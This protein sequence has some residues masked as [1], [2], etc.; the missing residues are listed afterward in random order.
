MHLRLLFRRRQLGHERL[1]LRGG[2]PPHGRR[3][4]EQG[5]EA[6]DRLSLVEDQG[7]AI[8]Q[9]VNVDPARGIGAAVGAWLDGK[10]LAAEGEG[11]VI[12]HE[13]LMFE[14]Q[15]VLRRQSGGPGPIRQ[16]LFS[17]RHGKAGVE[18]QQRL[19]D[20]LEVGRSGLPQGLDQAVLEG[21]EKALDA[22]FGLG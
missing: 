16:R 22:A 11:V 8:E 4:G 17:R 21:P 18:A 10:P 20:L 1:D 2:E 14:A 5:L 13:A 9:L 7:L 12:G 6:S 15:D 19:V 3:A